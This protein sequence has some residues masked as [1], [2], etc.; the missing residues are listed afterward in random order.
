MSVSQRHQFQNC[1]LDE[2]TSKSQH[3]MLPLVFLSC[4]VS[5]FLYGLQTLQSIV[6]KKY[7]LKDLGF[8]N[9]VRMKSYSG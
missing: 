8:I 3:D 6:T 7:L 5:P 4:H 2:E 1:Y 9:K